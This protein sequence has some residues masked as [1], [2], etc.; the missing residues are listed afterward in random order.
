MDLIDRY[1]AQMRGFK[2]FYTGQPCFRGHV[3]ERYTSN[4]ACISCQNFSTP[5]KHKPTPLHF[6]PERAI[7]FGHAKGA[8]PTAIEAQAVFRYIVGKNLHLDVLELLRTFPDLM[9][10]Y[11]HERTL[12]EK[13]QAGR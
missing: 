11:D 5:K 4:G 1:D 6:L 10:Y 13:V 2:R 8:N 9:S 12:A 3:A 7:P